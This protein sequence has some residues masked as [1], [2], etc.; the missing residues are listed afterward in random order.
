MG[1]R[2][3]IVLGLALGLALLA[4]A[5]S[6]VAL[7]AE[8]AKQPA[9]KTETGETKKKKPTGQ[10]PTLVGVDAVREEPLSQTVPILGRL[11]SLRSGEVSAEIPGAVH[12][13]NVAVGDHVKEGDL[14]A[15]LD[16]I[17]A[18]ARLELL[19]A[20]IKQA[21]ADVEAFEAEFQLISQDLERQT[22]LK[23]S[24]AF[25][26]AKFE[27]AI[28][29]V[30][31][32]QANI[33]RAKATMAAREANKRLTEIVLEKTII[34]APYDGVV[35]RKMTEQGS[36]V[37]AGDPVISLMADES[38]EVETDVPSNRL[39]GLV[40]GTKIPL[41]LEDNSRHWATVRSVLPTENPMTRTR[42]VR[43]SPI[44]DETMTGLANAQTVTVEVPVG[45]QRQ[46]VTVHKD[47]IIKRGGGSVVFVVSEDKAQP[48]KIQI[49]ESAGARVE[50]LD[51][52]SVGEEVVVRG[53]ERLQPGAPVMIR[54]GS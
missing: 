17:T 34:K 21:E 15:E 30:A 46:V 36:Y 27:D 20:E 23:K 47:A 40:P 16:S 24:G 2:V 51:G 44:F 13:L 32:A 1:N 11:V 6:G 14:I 53:N 50:V 37:K 7:A 52:L 33:L 12:V 5:A 54:K 31:K 26:R 22:K 9:N 45:A 43:F 8:A 29:K 28:Q 48:R 35:L 25:S 38:L 49:G 19:S 42:P 39:G 3:R 10:Q 18:R 4:P 41:V